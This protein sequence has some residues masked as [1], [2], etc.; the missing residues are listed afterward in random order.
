MKRTKFAVTFAYPKPQLK[1]W[2]QHAFGIHRE[3][4]I[5][6]CAKG[7]REREGLR[8]ATDSS[9][10]DVAQSVNKEIVPHI[11]STLRQYAMATLLARLEQTW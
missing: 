1:K 10:V 9:H 11:V 4:G 3:R 7:V 8:D 2:S 6:Q 5:N